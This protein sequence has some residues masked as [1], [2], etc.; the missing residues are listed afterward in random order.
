MTYAISWI[1]LQ[2]AQSLTAAG[3]LVLLWL[4]CIDALFTQGVR[5]RFRFRETI[6]QC[7]AIGVQSFPVVAFSLLFLSL[8]VV[9][10]FSFHMKMVLR[11]DSLVPAFS[12]V[13]MVRELGPTVAAL[14]LTSRVG[15]G[16]AAEIGTMWVTEQLD[17][18]RLLAIDRVEYLA[19]P[20]L[21]ACILATV[22][23]SIVSLGVSVVGGALLAST[24]LG[25]TP[26]EFFNSMFVFT[27]MSDFAGCLVKAVVFGTIIPMVAV[28]HGFR[29]RSGSRGVG[30][31]ATSAV[32]QGSVLVIVADF[33]L[34]YLLYAL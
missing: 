2:A 12:T 5:F 30:D 7:H 28:H 26:W 24:R 17:T 20:R 6:V 27:R 18:L 15:A 29:C 31:A 13:L 9:T 32:V 16:I 11:Q 23:L 21:L 25:Y 4:Q 8:M 1:G 33:I 14:L 19:V 22:T 34:T 3:A 10:E